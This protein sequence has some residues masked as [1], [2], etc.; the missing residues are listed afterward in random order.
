M[1]GKPTDDPKLRQAR[2]K[3]DKLGFNQSGLTLV[4]CMDR[5]TAKCCSS[6]D[7]EASWRHLKNLCKRWRKDGNGTALRIKSGC[8][9]ICKAGPIIGVLPDGVWY[10]RCTPDVIDRIFDEHLRGG[11]IVDDHVLGQTRR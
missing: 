4:V 8:I 10:G 7:M 5:K 2:K 9:G 6:K 1:P 11:R 3:A